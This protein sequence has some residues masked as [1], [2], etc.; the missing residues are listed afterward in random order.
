MPFSLQPGWPGA[1]FHHRR[2]FV[3][4]D[5][6]ALVLGDNIFYGHEFAG[7]LSEA[8]LQ[9]PMARPCL[10]TMCRSPSVMASSNSTAMAAP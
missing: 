4:D 6:S 10:P 2:R 5:H 1:G 9:Q 3:G 7:D 8:N